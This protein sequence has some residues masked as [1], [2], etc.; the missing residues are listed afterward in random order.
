MI[1]V[2]SAGAVSCRVTRVELG[3]LLTGRSISLDVVLPR[4]HR[5]R[6]SIRPA[7][8]NGWQLDSDPTGLWLSIPRAELEAF[9]QAL[10]SALERTLE[11]S[12]GGSVQVRFEIEPGG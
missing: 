3:R 2:F 8:L 9:D 12:N 10:E 7:A 6:L 5:F 11:T 1:V 4:D